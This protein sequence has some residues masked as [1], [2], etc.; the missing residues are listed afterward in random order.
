M[1]PPIR[2]LATYHELTPQPPQWL[3][4]TPGR[5]MWLVGH[6]GTAPAYML[7]VPD[8]DAR[9][10]FDIRSARN[11][12]TTLNRPL[13]RWARYSAGVAIAMAD[14]G[15]VLPGVEVVIAGDEPQGPRY[16]YAIGMTFAALWYEFNQQ[17]Y[18]GK[19]L[20]DLL[21]WVQKHYIK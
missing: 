12:E 7:V 10:T 8:L 14:A 21:E 5:E 11:H 18:D 3:L 17:A 6:P 20:L 15:W 16:E 1:N 9:V 2:L 13:P 19:M 4:Q